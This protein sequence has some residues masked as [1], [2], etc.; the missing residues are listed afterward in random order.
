MLEIILALIIKGEYL[1]K[2]SRLT[3]VLIKMSLFYF[4]GDHPWSPLLDDTEP[5]V[6]YERGT[7][8]P[9]KKK[10]GPQIH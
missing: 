8:P 7:C 4:G 6:S 9:C 5:I 10:R 1:N 2:E 3:V